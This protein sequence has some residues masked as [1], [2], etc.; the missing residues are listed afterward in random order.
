MIVHCEACGW[1]GLDEPA[2]LAVIRVDME[3]YDPLY[4]GDD[5]YRLCFEH[6]Q[7]RLRKDSFTPAW[8]L[9]NIALWSDGAGID[10]L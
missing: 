2:V 8:A 5:I 3:D 6:Y 1:D 9:S 10:E 4:P 7:I